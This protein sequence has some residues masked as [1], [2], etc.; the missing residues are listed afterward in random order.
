MDNRGKGVICS[1][2]EPETMPVDAAGNRA[3]IIM[4]PNSTV[5]RMNPGRLYEQYLGAACRDIQSQIKQAILFQ[6]DILRMDIEQL[7]NYILEN[8]YNDFKIHFNT[9]LKFYGIVSPKQYSFYTAC[10]ENE[11][12]EHFC[13]VLKNWIYLY[14]PPDNPVDMPTML[15]QIEANFS[16]V[17]GPVRYIGNSGVPSIT[18]YP[19]RIG[20]VYFMLLEKIGDDWSGMASGK[21]QHFGILSPV[22]KAEKYSYPW[23]NTAVRT[24]GE[25][26][27]RL[28]NSYCGPKALAEMIDRSNSPMTH[29]NVVYNI[30]SAPT[31]GNI[32]NVVDRSILPYGNTKPLQLMEH[33]FMCNGFKYVWE[34]EEP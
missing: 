4:D 23:R 18:E 22:I 28:Y 15:K 30:L 8:H 7:I 3:D 13:N 5:N 26:E 33:L 11:Q 6:D 31:P 29:K 20:P 9:L 2:V 1:I 21:L 10:P 27:G 12:I 24:I 16:L 34:P 32:Q 19:I 25:T 14:F 17:Y